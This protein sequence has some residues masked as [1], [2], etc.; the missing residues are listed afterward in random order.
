MIERVKLL[1]KMTSLSVVAFSDKIGV[2]P[3]TLN[4]QLCGKR[5]LSLDVIASILASFPEV[6]S[7]WLLRGEGDM[8]SRVSVPQHADEDLR[9]I[10]QL[11][12][13]NER[14]ERENSLLN[15]RVEWLNDYNRKLI[16]EIGEPN[17][18]KKA[19]S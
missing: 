11:E 12:Q 17:Q 19:I 3:V 7:E 4:Q 9:T 8:T 5:K 18:V 15:D 2:K 10:R 6:S 16:L 14:L 1:I 13:Q